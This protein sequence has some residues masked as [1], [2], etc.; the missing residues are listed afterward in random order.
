MHWLDMKQWRHILAGT[1]LACDAIHKSPVVHLPPT[2]QM[3]AR[4]VAKSSI[5]W[6][7]P[8]RHAHAAIEGL[9]VELAIM[10]P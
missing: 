7:S 8:Y 4:Q 6:R 2:F 10:A 5:V 3:E 1:A 9:L